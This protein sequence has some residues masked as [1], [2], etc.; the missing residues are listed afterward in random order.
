MAGSDEQV[1]RVTR[2]IE[3]HERIV[4]SMKTTLPLAIEAGGILTELK[5][6]TSPGKW[7]V[8][9][10]ENFPFSSRTARRYLRLYANRAK[11]DMKSD[12]AIN[13]ALAM[14]E[15]IMSV[16][17]KSKRNRAR[18]A[19]IAANAAQPVIEALNEGKVSISAAE[20]IAHSP[21]ELQPQILAATPPA[22]AAPPE[23]HKV[24]SLPFDP[25]AQ[26]RLEFAADADRTD[27]LEQ[28]GGLQFTAF[29]RIFARTWR[30]LVREHINRRLSHYTYLDLWEQAQ[31]MVGR[32]SVEEEF[33]TE[34]E[35][36]DRKRMME[37]LE[38][39]EWE[40]R[41]MEEIK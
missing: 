28:K 11:T 30:K 5:A 20:Q 41:K 21:P 14:T 27:E 35:K 32:I 29:Q 16:E 31:M 33:L 3:L 22:K 19:Y 9:V 34:E 10:K 24:V 8:F 1:A 26:H 37:R 36:L 4:G 39:K 17:A 2:V 40:R 13:K 25:D 12:L 38:Q 7:E 6:R 15:K 23:P 18:L